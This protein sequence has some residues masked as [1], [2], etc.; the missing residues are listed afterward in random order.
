MGDVIHAY[1]QY[2]NLTIKKLMGIASLIKAMPRR[3]THRVNETILC[4][5]RNVVNCISEVLN[6]LCE[7]ITLSVADPIY[8]GVL[9]GYISPEGFEI[10]CNVFLFISY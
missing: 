4:S 9:R 7:Q 5:W 8:R 1:L 6:G 3:S 2:N 10:I